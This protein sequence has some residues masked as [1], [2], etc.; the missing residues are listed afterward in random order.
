MSSDKTI[1]PIPA[2]SP[3][4]Y[5][6][7]I[8]GEVTAD[9]MHAMGELMNAAFDAKSS[10]SM[11][12]IFDSFEGRERGAG[13]DAD[14]LKSRFRALGNVDKYAV[15]GAPSAAA[16][17][18]NVMDKIIPVDARTYDADKEDEAWAFVGARPLTDT[19]PMTGSRPSV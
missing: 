5:A 2:S 16:T 18:I 6:F 10:V 8:R 1:I 13:L 4:V 7:R 11:L 15:V 17:M 14:S 19:G 3:D 12:L 9:D